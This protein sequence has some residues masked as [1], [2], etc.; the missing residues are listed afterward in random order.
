MLSKTEAQEKGYT[1]L[2]KNEIAKRIRKDLKTEFGKTAKFSVRSRY[3]G[4]IQSIDITIKQIDKTY[5]K[6]EEEFEEEHMT[7]KLTDPRLYESLHEDYENH[8]YNGIKNEIFKKI[9]S[10]AD[11]YN[12][13]DSDIMT[14]Y[15]DQNY[16]TSVTGSKIELINI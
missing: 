10:I 2:D 8:D 13:D 3:C 6:S 1:Q 7:L 14:D 9:E 12:Y 4:Y 11:K 16:Y 5:F 15:F